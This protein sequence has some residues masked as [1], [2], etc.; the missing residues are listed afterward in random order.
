MT[1][2]PA[3]PPPPD[4]RGAA[5]RAVCAAIPR[6]RWTT[7][8]DVA[9]MA[10]LPGRARLVGRVVSRDPGVRNAHRV[11]R[12]GGRVSDGFVTDAGGGP[13]TARRLFAGE[14]VA[15]SRSG[16]ADPGR[17][18]VPPLPAA[19]EDRREGGDPPLR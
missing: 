2:P 1:L 13:E 18:W 3:G 9:D 19:A 17:R 15:F 6:G 12:A 8:G 14:G 16:V 11:L 4:A 7:Y 5:I 10:G